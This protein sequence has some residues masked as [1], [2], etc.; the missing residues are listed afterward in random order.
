MAKKIVVASGKGGVGKSTLT[1][2]LSSIF[3]NLG[4]RVLVIDCDIG[5]RSLD[6][7]L[8]IREQVVFDWGDLI[9]YRCE[10][11]QAM[12]KSNGPIVLAAPLSFDEAFSA[13]NFKE[14]IRSIDEHFDYIFIDSPA[15]I[16]R[17]F[18][19]AAAAADTGIIVATP[20]EVCVRSGAVAAN[21]ML[22]MNVNDPRLVINRFSKKSVFRG[23]L[24]NIDDVIDAAGIQLIGIV[25]EDN[26]IAYCAVKGL[27]FPKES[28]AAQAY[29]R[30]ARRIEG[31]NLPLKL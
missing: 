25:P 11:R 20:D 23:R 2:G 9:L 14:L 30:I 27:P 28:A 13:V 12:L 29:K 31:E 5:L 21:E 18:R 26:K 24:M 15:G 17:G 8:G 7:I 1:A 19:L 6:L 22:D 4:K 10:P 3:S 16:S